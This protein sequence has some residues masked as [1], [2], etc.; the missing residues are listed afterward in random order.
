M[1]L[2]SENSAVLFDSFLPAVGH[3]LRELLR[4]EAEAIADERY[5]A[6]ILLPGHSQPLIGN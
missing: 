5:E 1:V 2:L 4:N 3:Q 6:L